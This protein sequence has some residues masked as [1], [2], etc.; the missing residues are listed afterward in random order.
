M[1]HTSKTIA[2]TLGAGV[3]LAAAVG[4]GVWKLDPAWNSSTPEETAGISPAASTAERS[5]GASTSTKSSTK[6]SE[7]TQTAV[8]APQTAVAVDRSQTYVDRNDPL[9]P[10][11]AHLPAQNSAPTTSAPLPTTSTESAPTSPVIEP[12]TPLVP[13]VPGING[14][15]AT[16]LPLEPS[17]GE[18]Q[19]PIDAI[20][21]WAEMMGLK[22]QP[23]SQAP[24]PSSTAE[25]NEGA[26]AQTS[27]PDT[28]QR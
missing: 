4:F 7:P 20:W 28:S 21:D 13:E 8:P 5:T 9:L 2:G 1:K 12:V 18:E 24:K 14:D 27:A 11:N 6:T 22:Q 19:M 23:K 15:L 26:K 17:N 16:E 10:P 3:M 25:K